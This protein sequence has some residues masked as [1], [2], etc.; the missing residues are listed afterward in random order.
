[1]KILYDFSLVSIFISLAILGVFIVFLV[2]SKKRKEK[3]LKQ[4]IIEELDYNKN[5]LDTYP[6]EN[7]LVKV[8]TL[9][10]NEKLEEQYK[11]WQ[12][13]F[14]KIK[15]ENVVNLNEIVLKLDSQNVENFDELKEDAK[16][17][18]YKAKFLLSALLEEI[19]DVN[20]SEE[21][22]RTLIIK[23][24]TKYRELKDYYDEHKEE[25]GELENVVEMQFENIEKRFQIF[26]EFMETNDYSEVI[27]IVKSIDLMLEHMQEVVKKLPDLVIVAH[28]IIPL[29]I[30]ELTDIYEKMILDN[31]NLK[32][33]NVAVNLENALK[34]TNE[35][36]E[37][38]KGLNFKDVEIEF[39]AIVDYLDDL[40]KVFETE[41]LS[42]KEYSKLKN[43][44]ENKLLK[45]NKI[46]SSVYKELDSIKS[47]YN[48]KAEELD[49]L[50][51]IKT[52][53]MEANDRYK[54]IVTELKNQETNF[55][56]AH[57]ELL[58][59]NTLL[60]EIS[61]D[62]DKLLKSLGNMYEDEQRAREQLNEIEKLLRDSK[63]ILN[64]Y[65]FPSV[66]KELY[67]E[68]KE[69]NEAVFEVIKELKEKPIK[70]N[71]L[72]TR[73]DTAR[74]L[75]LKVYTHVSDMLKKMQVIEELIVF[76]NKYRSDS[77]IISDNLNKASNFFF[78]GN[79][80][81]SLEILEKSLINKIP[82]IEDIIKLKLK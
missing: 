54:K 81:K 47:M 27:H 49:S 26:E 50:N 12:E 39:E 10:K 77:E 36:V 73:V 40:F 44:F 33:L 37:K 67:V 34:S 20:M 51:V 18:L 60:I 43:L 57:K 48:L 24:K 7:E 63:C 19:E 71:T 42:R 72:N 17:E 23:L 66:N 28:K 16:R 22:Y 29:K 70:I 59:T 61:D 46:V 76:A 15:D 74:D 30:E 62:L 8:E 52:R 11:T 9:I 53:L 75:A 21:K 64:K 79:Y 65:K 68:I 14:Q 6:I 82:N 80:N 38:V 58:D 32:E 4:K 45:T 69:A 35:L 1:M 3:K 55:L 13:R 31:Y 78:Q 56:N 2:L 41:Q 5:I 25:Y